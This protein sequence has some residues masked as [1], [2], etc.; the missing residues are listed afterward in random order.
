[1]LILKTGL[2]QMP[3]QDVFQRI[4]S[5]SSANRSVCRLDFAPPNDDLL[6]K[7]RRESDRM[8]GIPSLGSFDTIACQGF[9]GEA[10]IEIDN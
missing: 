1:V 2:N 10:K 6:P 3:L 4:L 8:T 5:E 9:C 7:F